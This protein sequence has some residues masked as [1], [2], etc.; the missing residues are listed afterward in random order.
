[1]TGNLKLLINFVWKFMGTVCFGNDH[2]AAILGF[3]DLQ[4]A[5]F[6]RNLE[7]VDLLKGDRSTNLY[8]IN[9]HEMASASPICLMARDSSTNS[10]LWHQR[11]SHLNFDTIND[12]ARNDLVAGLLKFKYHKE[13]L[14]PSCEQGKSKRASH[15]P[16]PVPNSRQRLHLLHMDLCGPMRI[17]SINGKR[18]VLVIVDDYSRYT[19]VHFLRSK[20]EAPEVII[21]FLKRI[22]VLLQSLVIIIR[23]DNGTE[24]KNKMLKEYF[25]TVGISYQISSVRT[26]QQN[27]VVERRN[28]TLVEAART[29][30]IFSR[31]SLFLR[32]KAIATACFTQNH[33]IIHR[34]FNNT[35]Y[36]LINERK[37]DIS[38]LHV[39]GALCYSKNDREDIG[40]L[41]GKDTIPIPTNSSSLATNVLITPQDVDELNP[42]AMV[43]GNTFVNP[44]ANSST[45]AAASSSL[46]NVDPSNMH[47]NQLRS[48]GDMCMYALSVSTMESKNVRHAMTDP[49]WIYSMQEELL[50]FERLD[51]L[52]LVPA[53]DNIPPLT[54]K[55]LFKNKHDEEQTVI[56]N[57]SR[58]VVRGYLQ[59]EGIDFKESFAPVARMEAIRIFLT[60]AAHKSITVFQMDVKT[61]FLHG[62]LKEDVYV[63]QPEGFIDADH[64]SHVYKLKKA[65]YGLKQDSGF[66]L[67]GFSDAYY[68]GCKDTFK[69]TSGGA[70]FIGEKLGKANVVADALSSQIEALK[71]ENLKK[72]DVGGMIRRDIPKEKLEPRADG[73][74]CLND[75]SWV[76]AEHQRPSGLLVQ[77]AIPE[78]EW[79]NITMDFITKLPKLPQGFDTIWVILDQLTKSAYFLPI[80]ENDP[81]DKVATLYL[82][83]IVARHGIPVSI[84]CDRD[85]RLTSN[86]WR[87]FQ[88]ALGTDI[89]MSTAYHPE[90]D[91]QSESTIQTLKDMLHACAAPYEALYGQK[92]RP[93]VCWAEVGEAELTGPKLIQ[94]TMEKIDQQKSYTDLKR[95]HMEFEV[96]DMVMLKVS[97][98]KEVVRF[99]KCGKLNPRYVGP[100][101]VLAKVGKVSYRMELP[102]ELSRVPHTFHVSNLKKCYANEPLVML[103][104]GIHIDDRLQ[105]VE[106]PVEIIEREIKRLKQSRIPLVKVRWNSRRGPE[107]TWE[108]EDSFRKK[109]PHLF[110]NQDED[111]HEPMFIQP[112]DPDFVPNPIYLEYMPLEDEHVL[113]AEEQPLPPVV[114]PTAELPEYVAESDQ[115]EDPEEYEDDETED[116]P[117]DYPM[118]G[119]DDG[120]DD[121]GDSSKDDADDEDEVEQDKEDEEEEEHLALTDSAVIIPTD[122]LV[123][124]TEGTKPVIPPPSTNTTTT[125][126]RIT[127]RLQ[128]AISFPPVAERLA[129]CTAPAALPSPP[130]PPPLHMP[131]P[132]DRRGDILETKMTPRKRL[133]LS[134]LGSSTLDAEARRRGIVEVRYGIRNTWVDPTKTVPEIAPMTMREVNTRVTELA[135]LY[136]HV[137]QDLYTLLED[138]QDSRTRISQ[139]VIVDSQRVDL[140]MEDMIAH[141]EI[142]QIASGTDG[143]DSS[144]IRRHETR[145]GRH[146][147]RVASTT[148]VRQIMAH[149]TRQ[150]PSTLSN[151]TN[152]NNMSPKSVQ[153]MID[154]ALLRN[155]TNRDGSRSSYEDNQRNVQTACPCFYADFMKCQTLNF[156]GTEGVVGLTRWIEKMESLF[157]ISGCAVE[158]QGEI[159]KL[160]IELW[161]LKVKENNVPAYTERF[162]ELTLICTKFVPDETEKIEKYV[163]RLP[164]N[165]YRSVKASK[166]KTLDET[167]ELANDLMDHKLHT[168]VER[169]SNNKRKVEDSFRN[170]HGH[171]HQTPK[172]QNVAR[173]YNMGT[174]ERNP[175]SGNLPK[176]GLC[177]K[178]KKINKIWTIPTQDQKPQRKARSGSKFSSNNLTLKPNLSKF[179]SSGTSSAQRSKPNPSKVKDKSPGAKCVNFSKLQEGLKFPSYSRTPAAYVDRAKP[180]SRPPHVPLPLSQLAQPSNPIGQSSLHMDSHLAHFIVDFSLIRAL[181]K[182]K[183]AILSVHVEAIK[184]GFSQLMAK[185]K[186]AG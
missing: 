68:A 79:D 103:L 145:D 150:G 51:V 80:R 67:T 117:V 21:K 20:D 166:P 91:G 134:T 101:K 78:W 24:F 36:E 27:G 14:C 22:T 162:Q 43:D 25:D 72:E 161:N 41:G 180:L 46:Q 58:L 183:G 38:F 104:E 156:K 97:P 47:T 168:Y 124:P 18:Y 141:Q 57:K 121:D 100:F 139:W 77:P 154:Q 144:S 9:L 45:S 174:G 7:G 59:K 106:E 186:S 12:L 62:S 33:S 107:S 23:T 94:E 83:R 60:Y 151:D 35:P 63:C 142:I 125:G 105:F 159:M 37:S 102:Q 136:E 163:S 30:L 98:W 92:C 3:V 93:L 40:K 128:A 110:T 164:D 160:E 146:A 185:I 26:P 48:D 96:G 90:T 61:A 122:E 64:P 182:H 111:E 158:N 184:K 82:K 54:L 177:L 6:V 66:K 70:Q 52:V 173:V 152:Q 169:Q 172:R 89:S 157:Q 56:R 108:C 138:A 165:I 8:T 39:F 28:R 84:I 175:Y 120:D 132:V 5:Y 15:P 178:L 181:R 55:W 135:E 130:L 71:L 31:A 1:M 123:S 85:G 149:L 69:S 167:I 16:K 53:S 155:S 4:D 87:S 13:H 95:K 88:K 113:L 179:L 114:S 42:N 115:E 171:Q 73:T 119:G 86:F 34:R 148:L 2:V 137:T 81:L 19:W 147:G 65:L 112:H 129:R 32:V 44:F 118:D 140:L 109:Y 133:C 10:W 127:V 11:L 74:L 126:A 76:K 29:M 49:A 143:R 50:Q 17:A 170:N 176:K 116:G 153:A 131:P 75:R 99:G